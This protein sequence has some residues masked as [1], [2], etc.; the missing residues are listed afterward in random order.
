MQSHTDLQNHIY[1]FT[2]NSEKFLYEKHSL[3]EGKWLQENIDLRR[4]K[5]EVSVLSQSTKERSTCLVELN[6]IPKRYL[7]FIL[8][9]QA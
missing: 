2:N 3:F 9:L 1:R 5:I 8:T 6:I 4:C 7:F